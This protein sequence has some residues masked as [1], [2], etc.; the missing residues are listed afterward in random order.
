MSAKRFIDL[1]IV[2]KLRRIHKR[3]LLNVHYSM[4]EYSNLPDTVDP[5]YIEDY[6]QYNSPD[7][8]IAWFKLKE[9]QGTCEGFPAGSLVVASATLKPNLNPYGEGTGVIAVTANGH[10]YQ[11]KSR[12]NDDVVVG[13]NNLIKRPCNDIDVDGNILAE[14]DLSILYLIFYTR[15]YPIF[16]VADEKEREKVLQAFKNMK[17]GEPLTIQDTNLL[18]EGLEVSAAGI[19]SDSF[20][21]PEMADKIQYISKLRE[22]V[23]RW[24]LTKYGQTVNGNSKLAQETVDEVN[25]TVSASLI[26]PLSMLAARRAMIEEVNRKFGT[27]IEVNLS[28]AWRAEVSRYEDIS[29]E[30]D[31]DG[32]ETEDGT[33]D[34]TKEKEDKANEDTESEAAGSDKSN[35]DNEPV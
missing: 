8:C 24:H 21:D 30:E 3:D 31:I 6:L 22:D 17:L 27:N 28:G 10:D 25:G 12:Y 23:K 19:K 2:D 18:L 20:T 32:T 34:E 4:F 14:I 26:I 16:K 11:F 35:D 29:G 15:L 13:F 33:E 5:Y 7:S 1:N 9:G